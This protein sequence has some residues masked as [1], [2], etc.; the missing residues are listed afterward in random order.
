MLWLPQHLL[1]QCACFQSLSVAPGNFFVR[2]HCLGQNSLMQSHLHIHTSHTPPPVQ[3]QL[4]SSFWK[5]GGRALNSSSSPTTGWVGNVAS[6]KGNQNQGLWGHQPHS[7]GLSLNL[8]VSPPAH[9]HLLDFSSHA[10]VPRPEGKIPLQFQTH[11][12]GRSL[13]GHHLSTNH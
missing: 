13:T 7:Y 9:L 12:Q 2:V 5:R 11:K 4:C 10:A 3:T 1:L 6:F 8:W